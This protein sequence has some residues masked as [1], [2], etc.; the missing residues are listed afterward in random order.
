[1]QNVFRKFLSRDLLVPRSVRLCMSPGYLGSASFATAVIEA[2]VSKYATRSGS[3]VPPTAAATVKGGQSSGKG[4]VAVTYERLLLRNREVYH[5]PWWGMALVAEI[6][7][8]KMTYD[9]KAASLGLSPVSLAQAVT[10]SQY[11][12]WGTLDLAETVVHDIFL[13]VRAYRLGVPRLRLFAAF[14]GDGRDLDEPVADMLNTPHAFSVYTS[15]LTEIHRELHREQVVNLRNQHARAT[16]AKE[17][18]ELSAIEESPEV[19]ET[20][21]AA[22]VHGL[23]MSS[24]NFTRSF[25]VLI[26][27]VL[28]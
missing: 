23:P 13:C 3:T 26:K 20:P 8:Y 25:L 11:M 12:L 19:T 1:M 2:P 9:A 21:A 17:L 6:Y 14:L 22:P 16:R 4:A 5:E 7:R 24:G 27:S 15:L 10:A 28:T 18:S